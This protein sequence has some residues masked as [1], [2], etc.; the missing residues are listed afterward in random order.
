MNHV[1]LLHLIQLPLYQII[2]PRVRITA[3]FR[4]L[5]LSELPNCNCA[6]TL[7]MYESNCRRTNKLMQEFGKLLSLGLSLLDLLQSAVESSLS[8]GLWQDIM[9]ADDILC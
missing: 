1:V 6:F 2:P 5:F 7:P 8:L 3:P 9:L 4:H